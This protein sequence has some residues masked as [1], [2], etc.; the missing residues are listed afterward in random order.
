MKFKVLDEKTVFDDFIAVKKGTIALKG[1]KNFTR[2]RV[3]RDDASVVL[4]HNTEAQT[5]VLVELCQDAG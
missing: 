4:L 2:V 3:Q 5:V 1:E